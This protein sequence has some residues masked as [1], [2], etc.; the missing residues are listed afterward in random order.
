MYLLTECYSTKKVKVLSKFLRSCY[1]KT[2]WRSTTTT[3]VIIINWY[4]QVMTMF[5]ELA[6][7]DEDLM[8]HMTSLRTQYSRCMKSG[9]AV[10]TTHRQRWLVRKLAFLKPH[11]KKR[12]RCSRAEFDAAV[13]KRQNDNTHFVT[14]VF[15]LRTLSADKEHC[16]ERFAC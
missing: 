13:F 3:I 7:A 2:E 6:I 1:R 4:M 10:A 8:K 14:F 9:S 5:C 16:I 15:R 11:I 12:L